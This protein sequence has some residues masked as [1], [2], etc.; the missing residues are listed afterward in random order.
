[1]QELKPMRKLGWL[2]LLASFATACANEGKS[3]DAVEHVPDLALFAVPDGLLESLFDDEPDTL[4]P[5]KASV[6]YS[7]KRTLEQLDLEADARAVERCFGPD[8]RNG[9]A[10]LGL[11]L[12]THVLLR[13]ALGA[14]RGRPARITSDYDTSRDQAPVTPGWGTNNEMCLA[15]LFFTVPAR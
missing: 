3:P 11:P 4:E 8:L 6:L 7:F 5:G 14:E 1:M 10:E 12:A 15:T 2:A 13:E 9:R